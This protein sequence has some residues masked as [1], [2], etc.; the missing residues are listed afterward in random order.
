[1]GVAFEL[2][3]LPA[4]NGFERPGDDGWRRPALRGEV[5]DGELDEPDASVDEVADAAVQVRVVVEVEVDEL[6]NRVG[7]VTHF[8]GLR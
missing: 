1:M 2:L 7:G 5:V 3:G 6:K 4:S 8:R